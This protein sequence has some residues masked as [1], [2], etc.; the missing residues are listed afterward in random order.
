MEISEVVR[1]LQNASPIVYF[2]GFGYMLVKEHIILG[3]YHK[4][5]MEDRDSDI[6]KLTEEN[7]ELRQLERESRELAWRATDIAQ[8]IAREKSTG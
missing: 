8:H 6:E 3:K 1:L 5:L 4:K 2:V 7:K